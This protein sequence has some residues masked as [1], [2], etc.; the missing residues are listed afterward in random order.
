M[1]IKLAGLVIIVAVVILSYQSSTSD[2]KKI[3]SKIFSTDLK[4]QITSDSANGV[5]IRLDSQHSQK[6]SAIE[7]YHKAANN[8]AQK[9]DHLGLD[10]DELNK[11]FT[12]VGKEKFLEQI[13]SEL[14]SLY[15][16]LDRKIYDLAKLKLNAD[17]VSE[18]FFTHYEAEM[19]AHLREERERLESEILPS[20]VEKLVEKK[21]NDSEI[22]NDEVSEILL[23]CG[24]GNSSCINKAFALLVD[25][26]HALDEQQL[27]MIKEYL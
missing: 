20:K 19:P 25:A 24:Q 14:K 21:I 26:H 13:P 8:L 27:K 11:L 23:G 7:T 2:T 12:R 4:K 1:K 6:S 15:L 16:D 10:G 17:G 5:S 22:N 3:S 18:K 9:I